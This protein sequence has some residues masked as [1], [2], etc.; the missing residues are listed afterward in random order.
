MPM[1]SIDCQKHCA[2]CRELGASRSG[3]CMGCMVKAIDGRPLFTPTG[4]AVAERFKAAKQASSRRSE[5]TVGSNHG[6]DR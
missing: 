1:F 2:E 6:P 4:R 5:K 3:L